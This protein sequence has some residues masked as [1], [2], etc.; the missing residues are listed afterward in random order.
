MKVCELG[1]QSLCLQFSRQNRVPLLL[2]RFYSQKVSAGLKGSGAV[3]N[4]STRILARADRE[5]ESLGPEASLQ[6]SAIKIEDAPKLKLPEVID[7]FRPAFFCA[8]YMPTISS[9]ACPLQDFRQDF[10]GYLY[11]ASVNPA[12][13]PTHPPPHQLGQ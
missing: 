4:P 9:P 7:C 11:H 13:A 6:G 3:F 8:V 12:H 2:W 5:F 1:F 10:F